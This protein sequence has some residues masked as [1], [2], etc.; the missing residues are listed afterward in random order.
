M[1]NARQVPSLADVLKQADVVSLHVPETA[2]T[3]WMIGAAELALMKAEAVLINA[4]RGQVV[5]IEALAEAIR[6]KRLL[7]AA[8]DVFPQEPRSNDDLFESPLRGLDNVILT[9]HIGGSTKEAQESIGVEVAAKLVKYSDNGTTTSSVN[10][11]EVALPAH[12]GHHRLLHVHQNVPGV[13][14]RIN[15]VFSDNHINI[16]GQFLQTRGE[17]GYVVIDVDAAYS[18]I[19][20]ARLLDVP[21]TLRC[22]VLF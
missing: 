13:M 1:G 21:G 12:P 4:A 3:Q 18:D 11:P 17:V 20:L 15:Q 10:F 7:G 14:S 8:I 9:P 19:A 2:A 6:Q 16:A 22:R 5:V